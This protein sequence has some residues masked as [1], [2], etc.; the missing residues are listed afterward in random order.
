MLFFHAKE[1]NRRTV[2]VNTQSRPRLRRQPNLQY[3]L[4]RG[5]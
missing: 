5:A 4:Y 2:D 3:A 1:K